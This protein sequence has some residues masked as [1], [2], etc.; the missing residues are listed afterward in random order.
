MAT[1]GSDFASAGGEFQGGAWAPGGRQTWVRIFAPVGEHAQQTQAF[2]RVAAEVWRCGGKARL[3][4]GRTPPTLA[5]EP[6]SRRCLDELANTIYM[7]ADHP[8][9][10]RASA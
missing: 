1:S 9:N 3:P 6:G 2:A 5:A 7:L 10:R 4:G 8:I